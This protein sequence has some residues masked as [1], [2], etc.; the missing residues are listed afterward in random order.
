MKSE[1]KAALI[2]VELGGGEVSL[3]KSLGLSHLLRLWVHTGAAPP[4]CCGPGASHNLSAWRGCVA[5][6]YRVLLCWP[7]K[8]RSPQVVTPATIF[9]PGSF[10][11]Y[12][13]APKL[14]SV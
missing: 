12:S 11:Y 10:S 1:V 7:G 9:L 2:G 14:Q 13:A 3:A 4:P 8:G 5:R 6:R